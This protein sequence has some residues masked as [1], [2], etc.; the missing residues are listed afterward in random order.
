MKNHKR[1]KNKKNFRLVVSINGP[2][3]YEPNA[4]PLRQVEQ[5]GTKYHFASIYNGKILCASKTSYVGFH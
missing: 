5:R 2:L 3:G 1:T 4:L